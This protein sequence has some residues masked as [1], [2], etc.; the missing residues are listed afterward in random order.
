MA[1]LN[2]NYL[3]QCAREGHLA[4][5][6]RQSERSDFINSSQTSLPLSSTSL[7]RSPG[8]D[9]IAAILMGQTVDD[10][11]T[12][13]LTAHFQSC[14]VYTAGPME[15][16]AT[17]E[18]VETLIRGEN[19]K[20]IAGSGL[21]LWLLNLVEDLNQVEGGM[22]LLDRVVALVPQVIALLLV[23]QAR[24]KHASVDGLLYE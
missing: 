5:S 6:S 13:L 3:M 4:A 16:T 21:T 19:N 24:G 18:A 8:D 17:L 9:I 2:I 1:G 22:G 23:S 14:S 20:L 11:S 10:Q 7:R 15:L 12:S